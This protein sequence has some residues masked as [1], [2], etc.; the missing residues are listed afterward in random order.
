M[1]CLLGGGGGRGQRGYISQPPPHPPL[2]IAFLMQS[3]VPPFPPP[4][5]PRDAL[6][7]APSWVLRVTAVLSFRVG[8]RRWGA[9]SSLPLIRAFQGGGSQLLPLEGGGGGT[10]CSHFP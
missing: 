10:A 5:W 8:V 2:P 9:A 3:R 6:H 1:G 7:P 4:T